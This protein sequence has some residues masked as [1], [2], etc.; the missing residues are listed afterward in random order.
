MRNDRNRFRESDSG[1]C[2][3]YFADG[4]PPQTDA[5]LERISWIS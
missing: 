2:T 4:N 5:K 3:I 1:D